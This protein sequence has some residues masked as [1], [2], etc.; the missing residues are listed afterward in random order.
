MTGALFVLGTDTGVGKTWFAAG[1]ARALLRG[2]TDVG[3]MKPFA[4]GAPDGTKYRSPD[5]RMLME[6]ARSGEPPGEVCPQFFPHPCSPF[7]AQK[8]HGCQ[9]DVGAAL[10]A[11]GRMRA[12]HEAVIAE[13]IGGAL[14][15]ILADYNACDFAR[16]AGMPVAVVVSRRMGAQGQAA[17]AAR[18]CELSGARLAGVVVGGG[19]SEGGYDG[20][21]LADDLRD[22]GLPVSGVCATASS[23]DPED[24]AD[25]AQRVDVR[26]MLSF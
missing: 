26:A 4:S 8:R 25:A 22:M 12:A 13:G 11:L 17:A 15:P 18:A 20:D 1:A 19:R 2:G 14:S 16:Q 9:V 21:Q 23:A 6:A 7:S 3:V 24:L 5:V 10:E